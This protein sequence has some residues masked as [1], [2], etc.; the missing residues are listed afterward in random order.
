MLRRL[1]RVGL[2]GL[3]GSSLLCMALAGC[4]D[5]ELLDQPEEME[6]PEMRSPVD[7]GND[8]DPR[9]MA[10]DRDGSGVNERAVR[11]NITPPPQQRLR[12][13]QDSTHFDSV[14]TPSASPIN[15]RNER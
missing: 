12:H 5:D 4:T 13:G 10:V 15:H 11:H 3:F 7:N 6:P 1:E 9:P 2:I 8:N 14:V